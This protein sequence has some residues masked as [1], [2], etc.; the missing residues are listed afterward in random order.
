ME[1]KDKKNKFALYIKDSS[2]D[3]AR[4]WYKEDNCSSISEF[5][6]KA[7]LFYCGYVS[8]ENNQNYLP[9]VVISTMKAIMRDSENRHNRNLFRLCVELSMLMNVM[10]ATHDIP[11]EALN[12]LRG[13]CVE[14]V[15]ALNGTHVEVA[16]KSFIDAMHRDANLIWANA[17][18]YNYKDQLTA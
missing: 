3:V 18:I 9:N 7:V 14:E 4:K 11:Q 2:L 13:E 5:I 1:N 16:S 15:K 17:I 8:S 6:E 10:A 12:K